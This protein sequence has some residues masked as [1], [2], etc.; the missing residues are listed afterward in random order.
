M[1]KDL[2]ITPN[3]VQVLIMSRRRQSSTANVQNAPPPPPI[4]PSDY[5]I[6]DAYDDLTKNFKNKKKVA[7]WTTQHELLLAGWSD[8]ASCSRWLHGNANQIYTK[9]NQRFTIP[10]IILS[11]VTGTANFAS[12]RVPIQ[13]RPMFTMIVGAVNIM[14]GIISTI[15]N[16]LKISELNEAHRACAISWDKLQRNIRIELSKAREERIHITQFIKLIKDEFDR[17]METSPPLPKQSIKEFDR[18]FIGTGV[19]EHKRTKIQ[20]AFDSVTKPDI[21]GGILP[22]KLSIYNEIK[23]T[24]ETQMMIN[25]ADVTKKRIERE[26]VESDF[27]NIF[28]NEFARDPTMGEIQSNL[29]NL[30]AEQT[31][32]T[33]KKMDNMLAQKKAA[34]NDGIMNTFSDLHQT[35][36]SFTDKLDDLVD[37]GI[38]EMS[39]IAGIG[40]RVGDVFEDLKDVDR[41]EPGIISGIK[42][43]AVS[44]IFNIKKVNISGI[45]KNVVT[46]VVTDVANV[47]NASNTDIEMGISNKNR[48]TNDT[49]TNDMAATKGWSG[50]G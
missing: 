13:Y 28:K 34:A 26:L 8:R 17:L 23:S 11:T 33:R 46:D 49:V 29:G 9:Y 36:N 15:Q 1:L 22:T 12:D 45:A 48:V 27:V 47:V 3:I 14:V 20:Q 31:I 42:D 43:P 4:Q 35:A 21:L 19:P 50:R 32:N 44:D 38:G 7:E 30:V 25:M 18:M 16:F 2:K 37:A 39:N 5:D 41:N 40:N 10:I 6:D 24:P